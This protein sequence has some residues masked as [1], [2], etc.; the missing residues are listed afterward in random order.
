MDLKEINGHLILHIIDHATRYS[1]ACAVPSKK[2]KVII[3]AVLQIWVALFGSPMRILTD[4]G[5][6]FS[7]EQFREMGEIF[8]PIFTKF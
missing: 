7:S 1:Q 6:E 8:C 5:G 3:S 4:N 2:T